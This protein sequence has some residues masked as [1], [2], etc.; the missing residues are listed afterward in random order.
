MKLPSERVA[1]LCCYLPSETCLFRFAHRKKAAICSTMK[2]VLLIRHAKS[3]WAEPG[4]SDFDRP[5]NE[6]GKSDAPDMAARLLQRKLIPDLLVTST[7]KRARATCKVF[8]A[9]LGIQQVQK[10]DDLYLADAD[11][12]ER[13]VAQLPDSANTVALFAHNPGITDFANTLTH[14]RVDDMPTC[15]LFVVEAY[16]NSWQDFATAEKRF[17]WFDYPKSKGLAG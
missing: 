8:E 15:A 13:V 4:L 1:F 10:T 11:R 17:L 16:C 9:V 12:F 6:R 2:T 3:S 7:A 5:L 14:V